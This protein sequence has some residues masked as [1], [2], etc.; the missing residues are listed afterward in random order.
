MGTGAPVEQSSFILRGLGNPSLV[1]G[2]EELQSE[3]S[4]VHSVRILRLSALIRSPE[5]TFLPDGFDT[6]HYG[7]VS[8]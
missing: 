8:S 3:L 1:L 2:L 7:T 6:R 4:C 5:C